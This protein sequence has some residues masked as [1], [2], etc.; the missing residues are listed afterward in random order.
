[1]KILLPSPK[2]HGVVLKITAV[3]APHLKL[4]YEN[5]GARSDVDFWNIRRRPEGDERDSLKRVE[6]IFEAV[7]LSSG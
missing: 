2:V 5:K 6:E 4:K 7:D 1:M 3:N